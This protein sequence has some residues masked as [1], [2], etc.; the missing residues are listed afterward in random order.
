MA[1]AI[2]LAGKAGIKGVLGIVASRIAEEF[3]RPAFIFSL[4]NVLQRVLQGAYLP[5]ISVKADRKQRS[6]V[7]LRRA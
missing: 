2:V 3:Y 6:S 5:L 7:V 1:S 4:E